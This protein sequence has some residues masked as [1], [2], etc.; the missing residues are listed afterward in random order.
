MEVIKKK[1][2]LDSLISRD[3]SNWGKMTGTTFNINVFFTQDGDDMGISTEAPFIERSTTPVDYSLLTTKLTPILSGYMFGFMTGGTTNFPWSNKYPSVRYP[4]KTIS[5]YF[6][7][8]IPVTGLTEDRLDVVTSYDANDKY[9]PGFDIE[10]TSGATDYKDVIFSA[11]TRVITNSNLNPITYLIDG[12]ID[13]AELALLPTTKR[14]IY[15][16]TSTG[17]TRTLLSSLFPTYNI[18]TT[19]MHYNSEGFN[20]TN[21]HLSADTKENYLFGITSTPTVFSDLVIERGRTSVIQSHM[22]LSEIRNMAELIN[23]GNGFYNL[24]KY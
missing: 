14:G 6:I 12:D 8:G 21:I 17:N 9:K 24:R 7:N 1:I 19:E 23:Y 18:P 4:G 16:R 2:T 13:P 10:S 20:E 11:G 15:Y 22:Q 5:Q 3:K